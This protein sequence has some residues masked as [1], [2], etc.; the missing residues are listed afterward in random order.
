MSIALMN[1]KHRLL[2]VTAGKDKGQ[3]KLKTR[4]IAVAGAAWCSNPTPT[5]SPETCIENF[6]AA[7][8]K[9]LYIAS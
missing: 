8:V 5:N 7:S 6:R 1:V 2:N 9:L 4:C 3:P